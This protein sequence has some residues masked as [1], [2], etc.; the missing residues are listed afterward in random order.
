MVSTYQEDMPMT[1][2]QARSSGES[3]K[4]SGEMGLLGISS[5]CYLVPLSSLFGVAAEGVVSGLWR[6]F[7]GNTK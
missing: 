5:L 7:R 2:K 1:E 3:S 4:N 6:G